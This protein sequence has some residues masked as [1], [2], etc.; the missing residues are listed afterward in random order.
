MQLLAVHHHRARASAA[1]CSAPPS[2]FLHELHFQNSHT[3]RAALFARRHITHIGKK[4]QDLPAAGV[5][6]ASINSVGI[7]GAGLMGGGIA[8]CAHWQRVTSLVVIASRIIIIII[9]L[10]F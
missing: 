6:A 7:V 10:C 3:P 2:S 8:M 9:R 5:K 4:I 1:C